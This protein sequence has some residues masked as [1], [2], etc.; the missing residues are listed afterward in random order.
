MADYTYFIENTVED[1]I[2][3]SKLFNLIN[4]LE[5]EEG[6]IYTDTTLNK[7]ELEKLLDIIDYKDKLIVRSVVDLSNTAKRLLSILSELQ[8]KNVI[9]ESLEE[10]YISKENYY[11][12][13]KDFVD[14]TNHYAEKKRQRGY[15]QA[16]E[17][18]TVGRPKKDKEALD[19]A[20]A[21]YKSKSIKIA[22]IEELTGVSASTLYRAV[23]EQNISRD[24]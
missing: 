20:I 14:I 8:D 12:T 9:L 4:D 16:V 22:K 23:Q 13:F 5:I 10:T 17:S 3:N 1:Y 6:N 19:T 11:L 15:Q 2:D 7:D 24:E 21:L 18:G